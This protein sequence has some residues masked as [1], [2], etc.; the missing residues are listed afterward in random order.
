MMVVPRNR[1]SM[2]DTE[3]TRYYSLTTYDSRVLNAPGLL[4]PAATLLA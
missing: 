4:N 2:G 1:P 3:A